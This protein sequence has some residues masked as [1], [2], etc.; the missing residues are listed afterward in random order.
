MLFWIMTWRHLTPENASPFYYT[1][2]FVLLLLELRRSVGY[3]AVGFIYR[4]FLTLCLLLV[5]STW[6]TPST[7][8]LLDVIVDIFF[9]PFYSCH[10]HPPDECHHYYF[11]Q[12]V[13]SNR[14][15]KCRLLHHGTI[16]NIRCWRYFVVGTSF[17][18]WSTDMPLDCSDLI[19]ISTVVRFLHT[20]F[21]HLT[22]SGSKRD[23]EVTSSSLLDTNYTFLQLHL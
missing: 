13:S 4:S 5:F 12:I 7:F 14:I 20:I 6:N 11:F 15:I 18:S 19:L 23:E 21:I 9:W 17:R 16:I 3:A 1:G 22:V 10:Q 2:Q 8:S